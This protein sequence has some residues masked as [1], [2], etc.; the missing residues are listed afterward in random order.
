MDDLIKR[1]WMLDR[2]RGSGYTDPIKDTLLF[3]A[4]SAPAVDA[5]EVVHG[6]W[7]KLDMHMGMENY[8]CSVCR[9]ECYVPEAMGEPMY[10]LC[11]N[12]GAR[13]DGCREDGDT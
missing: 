3:M 10:P 9:S 8:K 12:C 11:P 5:V 1:S 2:I 13:M 7:L 6:E 4:M